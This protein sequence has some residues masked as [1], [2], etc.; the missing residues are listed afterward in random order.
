MSNLIQIF[1]KYKK[2]ILLLFL[3]LL[4]FLSHQVWF[5]LFAILTNNDWRYQGNVSMSTSVIYRFNMWVFDSGL[6]SPSLDIGMKIPVVIF[7]HLVKLVNLDYAVW[8]RIFWFFPALIWTLY[9]SYKLFSFLFK[10]NIYSVFCACL[11]YNFNVYFIILQ[12]SGHMSIAVAYALTPLLLYFTLKFVYIKSKKDLLFSLLLLFL[13]S[14]YELRISF[15]A[16]GLVAIIMLYYRLPLKYFILYFFGFSGLISFSL[17]PMLFWG[18]Y[19]SNTLTSQTLFWD[20][21]M[22]LMNSLT[23]FHSFWSWWSLEYFSINPIPFYFFLMPLFLCFVLLMSRYF[24]KSEKKTLFLFIVFLLLGIFLTKQSDYPFPDFYAW[25]YKT[26][27]IFN[28]FRESSKFYL[29]LSLG[30]S[31]IIGYFLLILITK[32]YIKS[33]ILIFF[34]IFFLSILNLKPLILGYEKGI[35]EESEMTRDYKIVNQIL[36]KDKMFWRVLIV[37]W[38]SPWVDAPYNHPIVSLYHTLDK[39]GQ[40]GMGKFYWENIIN[41][42]P[43]E[44]KLKTFSYILVRNDLKEKWEKDVFWDYYDD[45]LEGINKKDNY[46]LVYSWDSLSLFKRNIE[47]EGFLYSEKYLEYKIWKSRID[48]SISLNKRMQKLYFFQSFHPQWKLFLRWKNL[49]FDLPIF[50]SSHTEELGYANGRTLD[51]DYIK[52]N[53]TKEYYKENPDGSIDVNL[54]LYFKPQSYFYVGLWVS[55]VT[56]LILL[57]LLAREHYLVKNNEK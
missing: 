49:F 39:I 7:A 18:L 6:W 53:F 3:I 22:S 33:A 29:I 27:P 56:L 13:L 48:F 46:S 40:V 38:F 11:I 51:A 37:P 8:Q 12:I 45:F 14:I 36:E 55:G 28:L 25:A 17:I 44:E 21:F 2:Q 26:L 50:E 54:T 23:F 30:Y 32:K 43:L 47:Q 34:S 5:S 20:H 15:I 10:G 52:K 35:F 31:A 24:P 19:F 16:S 9:S 1:V 4:V 41:F 42:F 57:F